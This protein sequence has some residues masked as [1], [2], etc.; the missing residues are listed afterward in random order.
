MDFV[1]IGH[2]GNVADSS[3]LGGV[4]YPFELGNGPVTNSHYVASIEAEG[5]SNES[6]VV[7]VTYGD[8]LGGGI[9]EGAQVIYRGDCGSGGMTWSVESRGGLEEKYAPRI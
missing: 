3:G 6:G 1:E 2:P 9:P 4:P 8:G 5:H 7:T